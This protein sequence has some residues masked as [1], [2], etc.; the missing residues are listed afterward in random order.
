VVCVVLEGGADVFCAG[1]DFESV[2]ENGATGDPE[3]LYDVWLKLSQGPFIVIS[4]VTGRANA[5]GVGFI[6][7]SDIVIAG[8][9][10]SFALSELI[11]GLFPACVLPFL[12]GRIGRQ[13]A[14]YMTLSTKAVSAADAQAWGLADVV[15]DDPEIALRQHLG[16]LRQLRKPAISE[17]KAYLAACTGKPDEDK[18]SALAANRKMF[19]DPAVL[20]GIRR[21]VTELKFPWED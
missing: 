15:C 12:I 20:D 14:H 2:A 7:A 5:G 18:R 19:S 13:R 1:G 4:L 11:F 10:A 8:Q 3:P 17:Y 6:A 16:R 9:N 21:Y